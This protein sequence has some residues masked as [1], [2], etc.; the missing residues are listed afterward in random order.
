[1]RL[2][3]L[4]AALAAAAVLAALAAPAAGA[5]TG[6]ATAPSTAAA[7]AAP[8]DAWISGD[9]LLGGGAEQPPAPA[10]PAGPR[11]VVHGSL[12]AVGTGGIAFAPSR[13]PRSVKLAVWAANRLRHKPYKWGG[14][15]GRWSDSGYDCSGSVSYVL[16]AAGLL[17]T[18]L[19]SRGFM[20]W[21]A[22]GPGKWISIYANRG[23]VFMV[24]A[25]LRFDT[26]GAGD[27]GPRW[28]PYARSAAGFTVR[29]PGGL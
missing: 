26:S 3:R 17:G 11:P 4:H 6:G 16:H 9:D 28:R 22:R 29:H 12:A 25:G 15:H 14:G 5:Q 27:S 21:G 19:D 18:P 2:A 8:G 24:V 20:R 23:H 13:A 1:M 10:A 7:A